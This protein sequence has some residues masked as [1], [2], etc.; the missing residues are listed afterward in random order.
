MPHM[1]NKTGEKMKRKYKKLKSEKREKKYKKLKRENKILIER[2]KIENKR[3]DQ[4]VKNSWNFFV[5][6]EEE[7][8]I[9]EDRLKNY[10]KFF[11]SISSL[12]LEKFKNITINKEVLSKKYIKEYSAMILEEKNVCKKLHIHKD[13]YIKSLVNIYKNYINTDKEFVSKINQIIFDNKLYI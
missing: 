4:L 8:K 3:R 6:A 1:N 13:I 9:L 2:Q 12:N 10:H 11:I 5:S 7:K